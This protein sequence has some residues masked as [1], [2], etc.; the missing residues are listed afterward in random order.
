MRYPGDV[1][2]YIFSF[3]GTKILTGQEG[4]VSSWYYRVDRL[5]GVPRTVLR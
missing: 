1:H 5:A 3:K 2:K 4:Y